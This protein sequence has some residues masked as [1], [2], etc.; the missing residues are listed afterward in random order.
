MAEDDSGNDGGDNGAQQTQ[1]GTVT[2][3]RSIAELS[4]AP[5]ADNQENASR[6]PQ[7]LYENTYRTHPTKKFQHWVVAEIINDV[8]TAKLK[9]EKYDEQ[10][11]KQLSKTLSAIILE[12]VKDLGFSRYKYVCLVSIGSNRGQGI[13]VTSR[14]LWDL[15]KDS[16]ASSS[17]KNASL[18]ATGVV[19]R[20][21]L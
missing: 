17:F 15:D 8:L 2:V 20:P 10:A 18:F 14:C 13:R 21:L 6:M 16:Y 5:S 7:K 19:F 4:E 3:A 1:E 9:E 12:R 11:S